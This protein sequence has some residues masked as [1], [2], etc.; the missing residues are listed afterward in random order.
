MSDAGDSRRHHG[1]G[2][3]VGGAILIAIGVIFLLDEMGYALPTNWWVIFIAIP[4]VAAL[5]RAWTIFQREGTVGPAWGPLV[6]GIILA[7]LA[8]ALFFGFDLGAIWPILLILLG[9]VV[10]AGNVWR[11]G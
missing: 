6:S 5:F 10:L 2:A 8:V 4:A 9:I 11:R 7:V 1:G 3:W